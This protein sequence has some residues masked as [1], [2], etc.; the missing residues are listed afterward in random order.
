MHPAF[1]VVAART[2]SSSSTEQLS[3]T[4]DCAISAIKNASVS[5]RALE[6]L[7]SSNSEQ[8]KEEKEN[9]NR[10]KKERKCSENG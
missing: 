6:E 2:T 1:T 10:V 7:K 9:P 8:Q 5:E 4:V 3:I